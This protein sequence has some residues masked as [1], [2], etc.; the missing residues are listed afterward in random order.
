MMKVG[1]LIRMMPDDLL[2]EYRLVKEKAVNLVDA[3]ARLRD[4][5]AMDVWYHGYHEEDECGH[6]ADEM[7]VGAVAENMKC[8]R[9]GGFG[10]RANQCATAPKGKSKGR[11]D[12]KGKG[13]GKGLKGGGKEQGGRASVRTLREDRTWTRELLDAP[14]RPDTVEEDRRCRGRD[15]GRVPLVRHRL[16]RGCRPARTR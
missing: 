6:E 9:C 14:P 16:R 3:R 13:K 7:E 15:A 10:H 1:L 12:T 11:D 2:R 8:F 4:P 5:S